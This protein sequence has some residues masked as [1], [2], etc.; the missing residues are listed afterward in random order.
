MITWQPDMLAA[1]HEDSASTDEPPWWIPPA[2]A[3]LAAEN[4]RLRELVKLQA[5]LVA[6]A[7]HDVRTSLAGV[8]RFTERLL[9]GELD[10]PVR[11][12]YLGIVDGEMRRLARLIEELYD[13]QVLAEGRRVLSFDVFDL[14]DLLREQVD[15][16]DGRSDLH[17]FRLE[18]PPQALVVRADC[19]RIARVIANLLSNAID[20]SPGGGTIIVVAESHDGVVR[21]SVRDDG[22]GIRRELQHRVFARLFRAPNR[23]IKGAGLGL[24]LCR[25]IVEAHDGVL[26]F[27][28][29]YGEGSTFWFEL[30]AYA[31][32]TCARQSAAS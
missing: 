8:L 29:S 11:E 9:E 10:P 4:D 22:R 30:R 17:A 31:S 21:V 18:L 23:V 5:E 20:Y 12:R 26:G 19:D 13:E 16:F 14:G 28:S 24:A 2:S 32:S 15:L 7:A 1:H 3:T 27:D 6:S 25:E